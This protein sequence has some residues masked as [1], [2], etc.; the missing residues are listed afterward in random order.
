[1][2]HFFGRLAIAGLA[3]GFLCVMGDGAFANGASPVRPYKSRS[4]ESQVSVG[5][6]D[7]GVTPAP[8]FVSEEWAGEGI[9]T[10]G[11]QGP[12][13]ACIAVTDVLS[14]TPF[15][16]TFAGHGSATAANGD[17]VFFLINGQTNITEGCVATDTLQFV[18][19][20]GRFETVSGSA[21]CVSVRTSCGPEQTTTCAGTIS[22]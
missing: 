4:Q 20:T 21:D 16:V 5:V 12:D 2:K 7:P 14:L 6:C 17:M 13:D 10:H 3:I 15:V 11:G 19:G 18:G 22:Y 8:G 1:M 9:S